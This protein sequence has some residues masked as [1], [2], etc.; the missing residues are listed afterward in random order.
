MYCIEAGTKFLDIGRIFFKKGVTIFVFELCLFGKG[1]IEVECNL[2]TVGN[3][4]SQ[5][6]LIQKKQPFYM[7]LLSYQYQP[8]KLLCID[9]DNF[10]FLFF[11]R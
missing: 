9:L 10:E 3:E 2:E 11:T 5:H 1:L 4:G 6:Y 7:I 8:S